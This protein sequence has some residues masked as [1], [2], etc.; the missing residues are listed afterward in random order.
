MNDNQHTDYDVVR[1]TADDRRC[2]SSLNPRKQTH[3]PTRVHCTLYE[4]NL[5]GV[6]SCCLSED[7]K[8]HESVLRCSI[9]VWF[10]LNV[11]DLLSVSVFCCQT[12]TWIEKSFGN[13]PTG[14]ADLLR[15]VGTTL[16]GAASR[17]AERKSH[18]SVVVFPHKSN[19][20][21]V[22]CPYSPLHPSLTPECPSAIYCARKTMRNQVQMAFYSV[23]LFEVKFGFFGRYRD[24][25]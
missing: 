13:V 17:K 11:P 2:L 5:R 19:Q 22:Y 15:H 6:F 21:M 8:M 1:N 10:I 4:N 12:G 25:N 24:I 18:L 20:M 3:W 9:I 23:M 7:I 16:L 14:T